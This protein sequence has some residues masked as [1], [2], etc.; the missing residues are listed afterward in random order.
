MK[1]FLFPLLLLAAGTNVYA[2]DLLQL[3]EKIPRVLISMI[4]VR[5]M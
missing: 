2:Q 5:W 3:Q 1:K 4:F